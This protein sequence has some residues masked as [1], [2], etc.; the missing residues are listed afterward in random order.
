MLLQIIGT[1]GSILL[2]LCGVPEL[3]RTIDNNKCSVGYGMLLT[4][5]IGELCV[6]VYVLPKFDM[7]LLLNY[8]SNIVVVGIMLAYKISDK[9]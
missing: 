6:F 1:I 8:L 5:F 4:W 9:E 2:A 3:L 7:P